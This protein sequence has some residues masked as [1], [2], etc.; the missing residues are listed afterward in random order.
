MLGHTRA[1]SGRGSGKGINNTSSAKKLADPQ[2]NKNNHPFYSRQTG[3]SLVHNGF[4]DREFWEATEEAPDNGLVNAFESETDSE[5]ALRVVESLFLADG[6]ALSFLDCLDNMALNIAGSYTFGILK[7]DEPDKMWFVVKDKPLVMGWVP[8]YDALLFA[9]T[10]DILKNA[11]SEYEV[12]V[13]FDYIYD[14]V[15]TSPR[16]FSETV[17]KNTAIEVTVNDTEVV[18]DLF[19]IKVQKLT[20]TP[21]DYEFHHK[22]FE[23]NEKKEHEAARKVLATETQVLN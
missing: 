18:E 9:S 21:D 20:P 19:S 2:D 6:D 14:Q 17:D 11:I 10:V 13:Y 3:I 12:K 8:E 16:L 23:E 7:E 4:I 1:A 15:N 5:A 22:I